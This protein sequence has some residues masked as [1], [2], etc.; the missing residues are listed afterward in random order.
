[1]RQ[2]NSNN[3]RKA[4]KPNLGGETNN[5]NENRGMFKSNQNEAIYEPE[6]RSEPRR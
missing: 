4:F 5:S 1:M 3:Y 6:K 2:S